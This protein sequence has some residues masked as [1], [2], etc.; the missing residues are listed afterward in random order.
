MKNIGKKLSLLTALLLVYITIVGCTS[1]GNG[2]VDIPFME[3][4]YQA[5]RTF[6]FIDTITEPFQPMEVSAAI[7]EVYTIAEIHLSMS[8]LID[9][10]VKKNIDTIYVD[11]NQE[12]KDLIFNIYKAMFVRIEFQMDNNPVLPRIEVLNDFFEGVRDALRIYQPKE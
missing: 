7:N 2:Q 8:E 3:T 4:P 12:T 9:E 1:W 11:S 6:V 5:G 10:V